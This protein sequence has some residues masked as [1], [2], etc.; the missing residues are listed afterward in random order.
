MAKRSGRAWVVDATWD[1]VADHVGSGDSATFAT[2]T[3][4]R[5][6]VPGDALYFWKADAGK[7]E[8]VGVLE[9]VDSRRTNDGRIHFVVRYTNEPLRGLER[10]VLQR[11]DVLSGAKFFSVRK[12][13]SVTPLT[14]MQ[15]QR[16]AEIVV[17]RRSKPSRRPPTKEPL[18]IAPARSRRAAPAVPPARRSAPTSTRIRA[19]PAGDH[20]V[21][22]LHPP[23]AWAI[24]HAGKDVE[25]RSWSTPYRGQILIHASSRR[26]TG[27]NLHDARLNIA[28][29]SGLALEDIP[30]EFPESQIVGAVELVD[31]VTGARSKWAGKGEMH[32]R[33]KDP[34]PLQDEAPRH[35]KL[36]LWSLTV[37]GR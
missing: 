32:W 10:S 23:W 22:S 34:V 16:L 21:L 7:L 2:K 37:P 14:A 29:C 9:S 8:A 4:P 25:N 28:R 27:K 13:P 31:V 18:M 35:G 1:T 11:D 36:R 24:I 20:R 6:W 19:V 15:H 30:T 3:P 17:A 26:Y 12:T 33:I 5:D